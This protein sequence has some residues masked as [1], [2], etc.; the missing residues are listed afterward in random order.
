MHWPQ[1]D[2]DHVMVTAAEMTT[3]E[4]QILSSGFPEEA[5]MEKVG[6]AM[7]AWFLQ[8][9]ALIQDGVVVIVGPGHNG[10]DGLVVARELY[11]AGVEVKVWCPLTITKHLTIKHLSHVNWLGIK[12]LQVAPECTDKS[13]WIDALFG[14][15]QSR[16][17]P[18]GLANLLQERQ[19]KVP[20][21]M[22]SL[23]LPSGICSDTGST[24]V[25]GAAVAS[26]TLTVGLVKKGLVQDSAI[27]NVG[28]VQR[29]DLG[30]PVNM[31]EQLPRPLPIRVL[32]TDI[33]KLRWPKC[34][35][36]GSKYKRGRTLIVA[37]SNQ[38]PGAAL[39][40]LK[41]AMASGTGSVKAVVP[42]LVANS[43]WQVLPEVV[44]EGSFEHTFNE[45]NITSFLED[46]SVLERIDSLL[47]G[48]GLGALEGNYFSLV[49]RLQDFG[50][51]LVLDADALNKLSIS[52]ER[53]DWIQSRKGQTWITP[54][55]AEF[56]R[57][58]PDI[59]NSSPLD[60]AV[61]AACLS[62]AVVLLKGAHSVIADPN[63]T[64]WQL[65]D[66]VP[67]A[68]RAGLGDLLA[69][70]AA[71]VGALSMASEEGIS[72]D[73]LAVS[74]FVHAEAASRSKQGSASSSIVGSLERLVRNIQA[75]DFDH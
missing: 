52:G 49:D 37:G 69:G 50:G 29:I 34:T 19:V 27:A 20:G 31:F 54:H 41:G 24:F 4:N 9:S 35:D 53:W 46:S 42:K 56:S 58:F 6:Q 36:S 3:F 47:I 11:L 75:R 44:L 21:R 12:Q 57:L 62:G 73:H 66:T 72:S 55:E 1:R 7:T 38:Y 22:V 40:A 71:G 70:F 59:D 8:H 23:D 63:G 18:Q 15:G 33:K 61:E 51:L 64:T 14:L 67:W 43:L 45:I 28:R 39:L 17:L 13:L 30:F 68:A 65:V 26:F 74:A 16:P 32:S 5:L 48:P 60:K 2:A 10:G 25:G